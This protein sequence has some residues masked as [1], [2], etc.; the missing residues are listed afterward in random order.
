MV[1]VSGLST[2]QGV[3]TERVHLR[4]SMGNVTKDIFK[5]DFR[6]ECT[7]P[8][9]EL[10]S[11]KLTFTYMWSEDSI[12]APMESALT[13]RNVTEIPLT[14]MLKTLPPFTLSKLE[15]LLEPGQDEE[16]VVEFDPGFRTDKQSAVVAGKLQASGWRGWG[17]GGRCDV[18]VRMAVAGQSRSCW[19]GVTRTVPFACGLVCPI[20]TAPPLR[21]CRSRTWTAPTATRSI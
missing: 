1:L 20:H 7:Q 13:L 4:A 15:M 16:L 3:F 5:A 6:A 12:L 14:L 9:L 2:A 17:A 19:D 10:S 8:L 21:R 18:R 11:N